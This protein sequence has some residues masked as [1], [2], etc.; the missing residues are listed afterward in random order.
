MTNYEIRKQLRRE[1]Q[2]KRCADND[3]SAERYHKDAE[4]LDAELEK[5]GITDQRK[6]TW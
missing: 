1:L 3:Q 2:A 6:A 4:W 5:R